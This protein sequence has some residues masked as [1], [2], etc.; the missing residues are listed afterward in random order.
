[1]INFYVIGDENDVVDAE[2]PYEVLKSDNKLYFD[3]KPGDTIVLNDDNVE[4]SV[5]KCVKNLHEGKLDVY[6]NRIKSKEEFM[7]DIE[8]L[9]NKTLKTVLESLKDTFDTDK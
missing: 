7:D 8:R 4:Y 2:K 6:I 5:A 3:L 1:M 9:A